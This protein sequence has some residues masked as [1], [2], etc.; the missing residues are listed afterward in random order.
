MFLNMLSNN[1]WSLLSEL[2]NT[3]SEG[4][5]YFLKSSIRWNLFLLIL[6]NHYDKDH[7]TIEQTIENISN[8]ES[9]RA[10]NLNFINDATRKLFFI[11]EISSSDHRKKYLRPSPQLIIDYEA[12][13]KKI[14]SFFK[15][16]NKRNKPSSI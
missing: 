2:S 5:N 6:K 7:K 9:S 1:N 10:N 11:K 14:D 3:E 12:Y 16:K 13:I 8:K 15:D 4:I